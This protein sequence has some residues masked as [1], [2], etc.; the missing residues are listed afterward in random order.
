M[1][2]QGDTASTRR[3]PASVS[4]ASSP[5]QMDVDDHASLDEEM[6]EAGSNFRPAHECD[7]TG[8]Q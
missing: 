7:M 6:N 8:E 2:S 1:V 5:Y 4:F 3:R